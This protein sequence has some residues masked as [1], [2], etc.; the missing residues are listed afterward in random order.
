M[1]VQA[2]K[3]TKTKG[4]Q[5]RLMAFEI[6]LSCLL[7][8]LSSVDCSQLIN[9]IESQ[10]SRLLKNDTINHLA[11]LSLLPSQVCG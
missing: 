9:F 3:R 5:E 11:L 6:N 2:W 10:Y 7:D 8:W 4:A 1:R